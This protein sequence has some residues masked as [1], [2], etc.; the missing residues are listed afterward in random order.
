MKAAAP[1]LPD[2]IDAL[3]EVFAR[4]ERPKVF[5]AC[6]CCWS[7]RQIQDTGWRKTQRPVVEVD[8]PG[9][10]RPLRELAASEI[11]EVAEDVPLTGGSVQLLKHYLPRILEILSRDGFAGGGPD[12]QGVFSRLSADAAL[13]G[14]PWWN[15]RHDEQR[16]LEDFFGALWSVRRR[17]S[18]GAEDALFALEVGVRDLR[19]YLEAWSSDTTARAAATLRAFLST[20]IGR[21]GIPRREPERSNRARLLTWAR[22]ARPRSR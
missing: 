1:S 10:D 12:L 6:G 11:A 18:A 22:G 5:L 9:G 21:S 15:W 2:A 8:A 3:Y 7:G 19:P 17:S 20:N 16:A 14:D 13:G 4:Y